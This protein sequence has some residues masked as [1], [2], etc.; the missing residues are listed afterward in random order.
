MGGEGEVSISGARGGTFGVH[1][2][3]SDTESHAAH[4]I[5][6]GMPPKVDLTG[7]RALV[8]E[9]NVINQIVLKGILTGLGCES[10]V[11]ENGQE[12][13]DSVAASQYDFV[14]MDV[15]MPKMDGL[16]ATREIRLNS[17]VPIIGVTANVLPENVRHCADAGMSGFVPKPIS[18]QSI[19]QELSRVLSGGGLGAPD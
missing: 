17:H 10:D 2:E 8:A 14:M 15:D 3:L 18:P 9:D 7:M 12:A 4:V 16:E 19:E 13:V 5:K 1:L 6:E 11:A